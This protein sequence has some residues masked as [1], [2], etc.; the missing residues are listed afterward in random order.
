MMNVGDNLLTEEWSYPTE[1]VT[2]R[3]FGLG[4]IPV[5]IDPEGMRPEG[6]RRVFRGLGSG[7]RWPR[8]PL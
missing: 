3:P 5:R 6:L 1:L 2:A 7:E 8:F 4:V